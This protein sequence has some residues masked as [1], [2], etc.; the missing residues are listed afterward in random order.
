MVGFWKIILKTI[1]LT[2]CTLSAD[3]AY[4]AEKNH[5]S[6]SPAT[7]TAPTTVAPAPA[8]VVTPP[9]APTSPVAVEPPSVPDAPLVPPTQKVTDDKPL[10]PVGTAVPGPEGKATLTPVSA[11]TEVKPPPQPS[12]QDS[13]A[14]VGTW[15]IDEYW[16]ISEGGK[17]V[18][19]CESPYGFIVYSPEGYMSAAI[20]C[21]KDASAKPN[22]KEAENMLFFTAT[23]A[24]N[25]EGKLVQHILNSS[26][27][28]LIG[29]DVIRSVQIQE[30]GKL[31]ISGQSVVAP[32]GTFRVVL[33]KLK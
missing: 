26:T 10:V 33:K 19:W 22:P 7:S 27:L 24:I 17:V 13:K 8:A 20:N 9:P 1:L 5:E 21:G 32:S 4:P 23:Y 15:T 12:I 2:L 3:W 6:S 28:S 31:V 16:R 14:L 18:P 30:D 29:K 11:S 25:A